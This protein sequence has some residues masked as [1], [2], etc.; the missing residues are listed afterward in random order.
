[1]EEPSPRAQRVSGELL[2]ISRRPTWAAPPFCGPRE[3][4]Q[5]TRNPRC[6]ARNETRNKT[7][8][9]ILVRGPS[10]ARARTKI[11][12]ETRRSPTNSWAARAGEKR[13]TSMDAVVAAISVDI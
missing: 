7:Q 2:I 3:H 8:P 6:L 5:S 12:E 13:R 10:A 11:E 9:K 4:N 1:M